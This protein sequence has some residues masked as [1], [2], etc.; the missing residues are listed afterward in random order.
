MKVKETGKNWLVV[1]ASRNGI[2]TAIATAAAQQGNRVIITGAE[3]EPKSGSLQN[4][5]NRS[6]LRH[7]LAKRIRI[8]LL[9]LLHPPI[10]TFIFLFI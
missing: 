8:K 6:I 1:G 3:Q 4:K 2:G 9:H 5:P 7:R 10:E